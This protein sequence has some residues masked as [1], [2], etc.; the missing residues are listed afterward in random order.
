MGASGAVAPKGPHPKSAAEN[1]A[2]VAM[3]KTADPA[4]Q[5]KAAEDFLKTYPDTDYKSQTLLIE[6]QAYHAQKQDPK[7]IVAGEAALDVDPKSYDTLLLLSEIYSRSTKATDLDMDDKLAKADKYAKEALDLLAKAEKPKA[8]LPDA[9]WAAAKQSEESRGYLSLGFSALLHKKYD[10]AKTNFNKG[11]AMY[12]DPLDMLYIERA[13]TDV[14]RYDD[15]LAWI[16]K[17]A[18]SPN[19]N[20]TV[21]RITGSDKTRVEGLKKQSQ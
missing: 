20:D 12:P 8:D 17:A 2:L 18:A 11:I 9:D 7:A 16:D 5:A 3:M 13:Y 14:K 21:K 6:A 19:A 10:D 1:N 15:A 4:A